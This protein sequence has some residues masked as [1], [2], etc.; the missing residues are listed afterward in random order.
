MNLLKKINSICEFVRV[1]SVAA[2][3]DFRCMTF[4]RIIPTLFVIFVFIA[5][6]AF[7]VLFGWE[8]FYSFPNVRMI[9]FVLFVLFLLVIF[10][11]N[12]RSTLV[13]GVPPIF[14]TLISVMGFQN[15]DL[16]ASTPFLPFYAFTLAV[17]FAGTFLSLNRALVFYIFSFI[18]F[19][20]A[21]SNFYPT[22]ELLHRSTIFILITPLML[23]IGFARKK[24]FF[25]LDEQSSELMDV[26]NI[27]LLAELSGGLAHEINNP[28]FI[29][30]GLSK[31]ITREL[32][33]GETVSKQ[34]LSDLEVINRTVFRISKITKSLFE[35]AQRKDVSTFE[36]VNLKKLLESTL[37]L[38]DESVKQKGIKQKINLADFDFDLECIQSQLL[39]VFVNLINNS[40]EASEKMEQPW[41]GM[42]VEKRK[43]D[44]DIVFSD[45]GSGISD[46]VKSKVLLPF[47]TTKKADKGVGLGLSISA[48]IVNSHSGSLSV[49]KIT[50]KNFLKL[51]LPL[52]QHS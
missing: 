48:R 30:S 46:E 27:Q 3:D 41:I 28:L 26:A 19:F 23:S 25:E 5:Y 42:S 1:P 10:I 12:K 32:E 4:R 38:F 22:L 9:H 18:I 14:F 51:T 52:K 16:M 49:Y 45:S 47:Y 17:F 20:L 39:Q 34:A 43:N 11:I 36:T 50:K 35:I 8:G 7:P 37:S 40:I 29:I 31:K 2:E 44:F 13:L 33:K 21:A 15:Q 6:A 24:I